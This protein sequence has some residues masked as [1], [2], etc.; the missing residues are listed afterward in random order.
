MTTT[1]GF[2]RK[3]KKMETTIGD[4]W[5]QAIPRDP[6]LQGRGDLVMLGSLE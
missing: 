6:H 4:F 3:G 1:V 5:K 2:R